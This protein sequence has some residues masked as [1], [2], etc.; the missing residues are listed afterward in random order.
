M[1][2]YYPN[3]NKFLPRNKSSDKLSSNPFIYS[4][5]L[6]Q[7]QFQ[8]SVKPAQNIYSQKQHIIPSSSHNNIS[9][10]QSNTIIKKTN[11]IQISGDLNFDIQPKSNNNIN[12]IH[13]KNNNLKNNF[14]LTDSTKISSKKTSSTRTKRPKKSPIPISRSDLHKKQGNPFL[15]PNNFLSN[16][17]S[18]NKHNHNPSSYNYSNI[19][20][21]FNFMN[22]NNRTNSHHKNNNTNDNNNNRTKSPTIRTREHTPKPSPG[23]RPKSISKSPNINFAEMF[24]RSNFDKF[25]IEHNKRNIRPKSSNNLDKLFHKKHKDDY[26]LQDSMEDISDRESHFGNKKG[27]N[28]INIIK[29]NQIEKNNNEHNNNNNN[30]HVIKHINDNQ[31]HNDINNYKYQNVFGQNYNN[32]QQSK[33][34]SNCETL[35]KNTQ[36]IRSNSTTA[37]HALQEIVHNNNNNNKNIIQQNEKQINQPIIKKFKKTIRK[38]Y[39]FTHVGFDGEADKENNQDR[40]FI[41]KNFA[42]RNDYIYMSVCDGHGIEGHKVSEYIKQLL[43]KLMSEVLKGKEIENPNA[44]QKEELYA[45]IKDV[46]EE[47]NQRLC[48]NDEEI[49]SFFSGSTC[50]S[51]IYT[52]TKLIC[53]NIGDSRAVIGK[54]NAQTCKWSSFELTRDHKPTE[55]DEAERIL[56]SGGRIQ[57]FTD[58]DTGEPVGPQRVWIMEDDVPGLAMTRSFGDIVAASVGVNSVPEITEYIL[59]EDDKFML[60]ASD[61]VW[62]FISS[63]ECMK[64]I[65]EYYER[66]DCEGCCK[67][68]YLESKMRWIEE[69]EVVD[70]ITMILVFFN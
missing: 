60:V 50:V 53:P 3:N 65:R 26:M 14:G 55:Q 34:N 7:M 63:D 38:I 64:M 36:K 69:E 23:Y 51:V 5:N 59:S 42:G 4:P 40:A 70:D 24:K 27:N 37:P 1:S 66:N 68:L 52:P 8:K 41:E 32:E 18:N 49:N 19:L 44:H 57:P 22:Y 47:S 54:Y 39:P 45:L 31:K 10:K 2:S 9:K 25:I 61:G 12:I 17:N 33:A 20:A 58:E 15:F 67:K 56:N 46:F 28:N 35:K 29:H 43:P 62:E 21:K 48:D 6:Q 13:N 11:Q 16:L 30:I